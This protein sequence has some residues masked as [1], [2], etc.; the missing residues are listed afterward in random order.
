MFINYNIKI[1]M[2]KSNENLRVEEKLL[3]K[4]SII[5]INMIEEKYQD[6]YQLIN[7]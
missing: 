4:F 5:I 7:N 3:K 6:S 2:E 1:L